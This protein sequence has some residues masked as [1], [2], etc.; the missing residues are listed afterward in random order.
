[1]TSKKLLSTV[2]A[3]ALALGLGVGASQAQVAD[4]AGP[5]VGIHA[6]YGGANPDLS[7]GSTASSSAA[8]AFNDNWDGGLVGA[9]AG[10]N[11]QFDRAVVGVEADIDWLVGWDAK[12]LGVS[13]S[14]DDAKSDMDLLASIRA[15]LG[16]AVADNLLG[17]VTGGIAFTDAEATLHAGTSDKEKFEWNDVGG[18]V[19]LGFEYKVSESVSFR[20]EGLYYFFGEEDWKCQTSCGGT[21][22]DTVGNID[23][24]AFAIRAGLTFHF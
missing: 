24:D 13:D 6:G 1:M 15:R 2:C 8:V 21:E 4:W 20:T 5:Y 18:V 23:L 9:Y 12:G 19:G 10:Y 14:S 11:F 3:A 22:G 16:Y 7:F 17:Y